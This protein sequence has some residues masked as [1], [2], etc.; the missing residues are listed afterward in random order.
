MGGTLK[1]IFN[2]SSS[3]LD[4]DLV[5]ALRKS[6]G[7]VLENIAYFGEHSGLK[8]KGEVDDTEPDELK[9]AQNVFSL[10]DFR[11]FDSFKDRLAYMAVDL[12]Y[13]ASGNPKKAQ[14]TS[15]NYLPKI[16][17]NLEKKQ[18]EIG[19]DTLDGGKYQDISERMDSMKAMITAFTAPDGEKL[20][21]AY[22]KNITEEV[23]KSDD[24]SI[25][26][27]QGI[28]KQLNNVLEQD[29]KPRYQAELN[30]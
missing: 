17:E 29:S 30:R 14:S 15:G 2:F 24:L 6:R 4:Y 16:L 10:A 28:Y 18:A 5:V 27:K 21:K 3:P 12:M 23:N 22:V 11:S 25:E 9:K 26:E 8:V 13:E 7:D 1:S 20:F 19:P